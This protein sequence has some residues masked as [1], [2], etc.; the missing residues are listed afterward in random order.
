M[1]ALQLLHYL[2][3]LEAQEVDLAN[4]S[5]EVV[6]ERMLGGT[7][8]ELCHTEPEEVYPHSVELSDTNALRFNCW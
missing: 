3:H 8:D 7:I 5:L 1:N 6:Y 2:L 4:V